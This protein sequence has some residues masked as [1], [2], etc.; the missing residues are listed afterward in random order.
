MKI[1]NNFILLKSLY[2]L[3][4]ILSL[5]LFFST[6]KVE[7]KSF[8]I[9]NIEISKPFEIKFDKNLVIDQGFKEA[10]FE[11]ISLILKDT[12]K[13]IIQ[14]IKLNEIKGMIETFTIK[15]ERFI[16]ETYYVNLGF[17]SIKK[18]FWFLRKKYFSIN[19]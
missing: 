7:A 14:N 8:S 10:F 1:I 17:R 3:L 12:D 13:K 16:N 11:L 9:E 6:T 15:E 18:S 4:I 2:I 5:F 19:T